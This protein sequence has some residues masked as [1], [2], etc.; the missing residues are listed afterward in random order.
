[1]ALP[2]YNLS[3]NAPVQHQ[4]SSVAKRRGYAQVAEFIATD[5][6]LAVYHRFD[7]T[8]ARVLLIMQS[9]LLYK[10]KQLDEIDA[11]D[12]TDNDEKRLLASGTILEEFP[13]PPDARDLRKKQLY[14]DLKLLLKEYCMLNEREI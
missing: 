4:L 3:Q 10:Q 14:C 1:M 7:R 6:E 11:Q 13:G 8:A 12:A 9:E 2:Y 5:K